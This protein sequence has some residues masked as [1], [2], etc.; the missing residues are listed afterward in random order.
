M[1]DVFD[2]FFDVVFLL[3][4]SCMVLYG[5]FV[6]WYG[7][8]LMVS[9]IFDGLRVFEEQVDFDDVQILCFESIRSMSLDSSL[10][11]LIFVVDYI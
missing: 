7:C 8:W 9:M 2:S 4:F 1:V 6:T 10:G 11:N 5:I 3:R